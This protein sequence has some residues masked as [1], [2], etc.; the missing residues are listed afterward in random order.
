MDWRRARPD[1]PLAGISQASTEVDAL[2]VDGCPRQHG[3]RRL[4]GVAIATAVIAIG[5]A[6]PLAA[7]RADQASPARSLAASPAP[8]P[9]GP[10]GAAPGQP[11]PGPCLTPQ[12]R[13]GRSPTPATSSKPRPKPVEPCASAAGRFNAALSDRL[14][15]ALP[16]TDLA[17]R[18]DAANKT[19]W[20]YLD[21]GTYFAEVAVSSGGKVVGE[22]GIKISTWSVPPTDACPTGKQHNVVVGR[23]D[24]TA[25][26]LAAFNYRPNRD[27]PRDVAPVLAPEPPLT[28]EQLETIG[29]D[30]RLT[31]F[32]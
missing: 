2:I 19:Q 26:V 23:P 20:F 30:P 5:V 14:V 31:L 15:R 11:A 32:P 10:T 24:H 4:T 1:V 13:A 17:N 3:P 9:D 18:L 8:S 21:D 16:G 7:C 28:A 12:P 6:G 22:V 27:R 29:L 25:V